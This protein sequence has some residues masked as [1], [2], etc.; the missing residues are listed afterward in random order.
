MHRDRFFRL[1]RASFT[2]EAA[3]LVP[4]LI[5]LMVLLTFFGLHLLDRAVLTAAVCEEAVTGKE[6]PFSPMLRTTETQRSGTE[7]PSSRTVT[8]LLTTRPGPAEMAWAFRTEVSYRISGAPLLLR[9][10]RAAAYA[11]H[12][13]KPASAHTSSGGPHE[14][15]L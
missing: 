4:G 8:G 14:D 10:A 9:K 11:V 6:V 15:I 12:A 1:S 5:L 7:A 3:F 13:L 2:V